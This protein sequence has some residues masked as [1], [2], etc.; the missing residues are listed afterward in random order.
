MPQEK[1]KALYKGPTNPDGTPQVWLAEEGVDPGD[2]P[3]LPTEPGIPARHLTQEEYDALSPRNKE[4]VR[5]AM[6]AGAPLYAVRSD[7]ELSSTSSTAS[8]KTKEGE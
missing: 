7:K 6:H 8:A 1:F 4:R 5:E 3:A 2:G